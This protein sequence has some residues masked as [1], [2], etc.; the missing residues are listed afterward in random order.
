MDN[1]MGTDCGSGDGQGG[2]EHGEKIW[3]TVTK[4]Q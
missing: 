3:T 2:G 1:R 4:Q